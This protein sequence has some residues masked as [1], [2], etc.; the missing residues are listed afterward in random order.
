MNKLRSLSCWMASRPIRFGIFPAILAGIL[1]LVIAAGA[2]QAAPAAQQPV[3][4]NHQIMVAANGI[5]CVFCHTDALRSP[6]AGMPSLEKCM[7]CH[8]II[9]PTVPDIQKL[10]EYWNQQ[11]PIPWVRVNELPRYVRFNHQAHVVAGAQNC[12]SCHGD[13]AHMTVYQQAYKLNMGFCMNCHLKQPNRP[14]LIMC[15]TCHQ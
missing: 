1:L 4:F 15:D 2:N 5:N 7:G 10:T 3:P 14:D 8:K 12:E 11:K 6:A 13:V 9:D